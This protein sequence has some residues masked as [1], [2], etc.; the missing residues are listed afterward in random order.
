MNCVETLRKIQETIPAVT[1]IEAGA[2]GYLDGLITPNVSVMKGVDRHGRAFVTFCA[3]S[4][5]LTD[6]GLDRRFGITTIFQRYSGDDAPDVVTQATNAGR[7]LE[8]LV[9]GR[10]TA[11]DLKRLEELVTTGKTIVSYNDWRGQTQEIR[12]E[13]C[14]PE[15]AIQGLRPRATA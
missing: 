5:Q 11:V 7:R 12:F 2:T 3:R 9:A 14:L 10:A 4:E 13:L 8:F 15:E 1:S 6:Y